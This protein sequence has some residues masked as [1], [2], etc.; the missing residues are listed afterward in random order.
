[1]ELITDTK[2]I[3]RI[4]IL[5][6]LGFLFLPIVSKNLFWP[7]MSSW[8]YLYGWITLLLIFHPKILI[9]K[10]VLFIYFFVTLYLLLMSYGIYNI[11]FDWIF[12]S[13]KYLFIS[14]TILQYFYISKDYKGLIIVMRFTLV[15]IVITTITSFI[16]MQRFPNAAREL[17]GILQ[18]H[19]E[20]YLITIYE[21]LGIASYDFFYGLAFSLPVF[22]SYWKLK[23][24]KIKMKIF[25]FS[26]ITLS[27]IGLIKSQ[28]TTPLLFSIIASLFAFWTPKS[29]PNTLFRYILGV[30]LLF[31][32]YG[33]LID[34][35]FY[36]S[37]LIPGN[38]LSDRFY[39]VADFLRHGLGGKSK[40]LDVRWAR[41][42][43]QIENF[44]T[45]PIFGGYETTGHVFWIDTLAQFGLLG[46]LPWVLLLNDQIR[47]NLKYIHKT[48]R[49]Y[50]IIPIVMFIAVGFIRN[51]GGARMTMF[52]FFIIPSLVLIKNQLFKTR[53]PNKR[54]PK[55]A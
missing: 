33:F 21:R 22:I 55:Y 46:L 4:F 30:S 17:A 35:I 25:I 43:I 47:R 7:F 27:F 23:P 49:I 26:L 12:S 39:D 2:N 31:I 38:I 32:A 29:N 5:F 42:P 36:L 16:G 19:N 34:F 11:D 44:L 14:I 28:F 45:S 52:I 37:S 20:T 18:L 10:P 54:E 15:F 3:F 40:A 1:M 24:I 50:Y 51:L 13:L 8:F 48:D 41:V 9:S 6:I 53:I